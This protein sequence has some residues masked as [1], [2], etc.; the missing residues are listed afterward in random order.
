MKFI[1]TALPVFT[2]TTFN[3]GNSNAYSTM[4]PSVS[5]LT[6]NKVS[7]FHNIDLIR[8]KSLPRNLK[9]H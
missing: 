6:N 1:E 9:K 8:I 3:P 7:S 5:Y 4:K 2:I